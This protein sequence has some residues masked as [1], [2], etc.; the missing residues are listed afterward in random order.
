MAQ[1]IKE[2]SGVCDLNI[3]R[4]IQRPFTISRFRERLQFLGL[5][6]VRK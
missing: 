5:Y 2:S 4:V 6:R 3:M 1:K